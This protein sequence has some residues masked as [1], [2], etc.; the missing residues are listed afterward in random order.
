M[1]KL[2]PFSG[3]SSATTEDSN[4]RDYEQRML[5]MLR[6]LKANTSTP[7]SLWIGFRQAPLIGLV[8]EPAESLRQAIQRADLLR[9]AGSS[10]RQTRPGISV[11]LE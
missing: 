1:S 10:A 3:K 7:R 8:S 6:R 9:I 2:Q 11:W 5:M 4:Y